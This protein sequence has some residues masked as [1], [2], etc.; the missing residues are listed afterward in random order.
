MKIL[1]I[2][3]LIILTLTLAACG[4]G[5]TEILGPTWQWEAFQDT[6]GIQ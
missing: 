4:G 2:S 3:V 6:A 1:T 5:E